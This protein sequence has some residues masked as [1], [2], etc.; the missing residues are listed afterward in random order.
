MEGITILRARIRKRDKD[1][2]QA[3]AFLNL[4]EGELA[5]MIR[6]GLR[7]ILIERGVLVGNKA[8]RNRGS[9]GPT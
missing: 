8:K 1:I 7:K 4:E 6:D 5:D 3:I 9:Q 2:K